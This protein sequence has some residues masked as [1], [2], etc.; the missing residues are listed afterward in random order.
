[1]EVLQFWGL[2]RALQTQRLVHHVVNAPAA[3]AFIASIRSLLRDQ[4]SRRQRRTRRNGIRSDPMA[5]RVSLCR[6]RHHGN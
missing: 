4:S 1:M 3:E 5:H 6:L 2:R